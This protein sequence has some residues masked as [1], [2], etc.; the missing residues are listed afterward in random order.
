MQQRSL[1]ELQ[2]TVSLDYSA[3][4]VPLNMTD[5]S[6]DI[7]QLS[8]EQRNALQQFTSV[9]DQ[10]T[11]VAIPLL[12]SCQ[13]NVQVWHPLQYL[14]DPFID[15]SQIAIAR[16]YDGAPAD[17]E[18]EEPLPIQSSRRQET[19]LSS[20]S[21]ANNLSRSSYEP[22][23]RVTDAPESYRPRQAPLLVSLIFT[24]FNLLYAL[25]S[26]SFGLLSCLFP[27]LPRLVSRLSSRNTSRPSFR[28]TSGRRPLNARDTAARFI[29]E[30]EEEYGSNDLPIFEGGYAQ[31]YDKAKD[32]LKYLI[33]VL[34]SPEHDDTNSFVRDTLL[35][36]DVLAFIQD[37][38]DKMIVWAGNV[39]DSEAYQVASS[40]NCTKFPFVGLVVYTP[41]TSSMSLV[42]RISGPAPPS[43]LIR[44][45][46]VAVSQNNEHLDSVRSQ[47]T[48]QQASRHIR[49][50]QNSAYERSL[51]QDRERVRLKKEAAAAKE[52]EEKEA[53]REEEARGRNAR[54]LAQ[55][56]RWRAQRISNE[57]SELVKEAVRISIRMP[58]GE[59]ILRKFDPHVTLEDLYAFVECF[60]IIKEEGISEKTQTCP[61]DFEH[62]YQFRL[63]S[64]MPREA[65]ELADG[66][67]IR[68]RIGK[69]G[70]LIVERL[71]DEDS[72][73]EI[74]D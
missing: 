74:A 34:I 10:D 41:A 47:R 5:T 42:S 56:K 67:T 2:E 39:Q 18:P 26:R 3:T 48:Q 52:R 16:F 8:E 1:F 33:V 68:E 32:E 17:V 69:S 4:P 30:F 50:A 70:N 73:T 23:P 36:P 38:G 11:N 45:F 37:Q 25:L 60:D 13:W 53:R 64:P 66:G 31:A 12:R 59:R 51:T 65:Y 22:A 57:P 29:R 28:G 72:E 43:L 21:A 44:K 20:L 24:P 49:E 14:S 15:F 40:V 71:E 6:L 27:F 55:W 35:H 19:L 7:D 9:T 58:S 54:D 62:K 46:R 61:E 63:V